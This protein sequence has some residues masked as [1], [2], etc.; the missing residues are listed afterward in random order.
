MLLGWL[1]LVGAALGPVTVAVVAHPPRALEP[2]SLGYLELARN[3]A[4]HGAFGRGPEGD[5]PELAR[6]PGYPAFAALFQP[7]RSEARLRTLLVA[8]LLLL[9]L[10]GAAVA[11]AVILRGGSRMAGLGV[12]ALL[13]LNPIAPAFALSLLSEGLF[14]FVMVAAGLIWLEL[15]PLRPRAA[16]ALAGLLTGA[17]ILVRPIGVVLVPAVLAGAL[18]PPMAGAGSVRRLGLW[19]LFVALLPMAWMMRNGLV[20]DAWLVTGTPAAYTRTVFAGAGDG[21]RGPGT[22]ARF[23]LHLLG[24]AGR[25]AFGPGEWALRRVWFGETGT[26]AGMAPPPLLWIERGRDGLRFAAVTSAEE[27]PQE[28]PQGKPPPAP[29]GR[30]VRA[31]SGSRSPG[32]WI[33]LLWSWGMTGLLYL[34]VLRAIVRGLRRA[35]TGERSREFAIDRSTVVSAAPAAP[36]PRAGLDRA[37]LVALVAAALLILAA[38]GGHANARFRLPALP[39]L[40]WLAGVAGAVGTAG[41]AGREGTAGTAGTAG[42][43]GTAGTAGEAGASG[44]R[45]DAGRCRGAEGPSAEDPRR[46]R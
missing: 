42:R 10:T 9:L 30:P 5:L 40:A 38:A 29:A 28:S 43:A 39:W 1:L 44:A 25:V 35:G 7:W 18:W 14:I 46:S 12:A 19:L 13:L 4:V 32:V 41:G 23:A 21:T 26:R 16:A 33:L 34:A 3:L 15:R 22:T 24:G 6:T 17:A 20:H 27:S 37:C 2:D 31:G 45:G 36:R 8:Q 11:R